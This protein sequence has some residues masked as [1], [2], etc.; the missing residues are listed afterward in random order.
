MLAARRSFSE[1][2][3]SA[4][5]LQL[6]SQQRTK[7]EISP[8]RRRAL[9]ARSTELLAR[10]NGKFFCGRVCESLALL[11]FASAAKAQA[12]RFERFFAAAT[13]S[14]VPLSGFAGRDAR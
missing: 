2:E 9:R 4:S 6:T 8:A 11:R 3:P 1:G 13:R 10:R 7:A 12:I 5:E 14:H